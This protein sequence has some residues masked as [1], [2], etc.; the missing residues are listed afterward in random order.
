VGVVGIITGETKN[1]LF[2]T[3]AERMPFNVHPEKRRRIAIEDSND[4]FMKKSDTVDEKQP[5]SI[6]SEA[7][8]SSHGVKAAEHQQC[9]YACRHRVIQLLKKDT[10]IG[11]HLPAMNCRT[12]DSTLKSDRKGNICIFYSKNELFNS[13]KARPKKR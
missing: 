12:S 1:C 4:S 5:Y 9:T 7:C 11:L 3:I 8:L 2:V 10:T 6:L 13:L